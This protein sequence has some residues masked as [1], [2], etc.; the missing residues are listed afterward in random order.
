M[1]LKK[2]LMILLSLVYFD[3]VFNLNAYDS[4]SFEIFINIFL[5]DC[6]NSFLVYFLTSL[7][8]KKINKLVSYLIYAFL[9]FWYSLYYVFYRVFITPFS[10]ALFRQSD[11]LLKFGKNIVISVL[12]N[13]HVLILFMLPLIFLIVFRKRFKFDK[14]KFKGYVWGFSLLLCVVSLYVLNIFVQERGFGST[15]NLYFETNNVSL[16]IEKLGVPAA[17]FL[18]FYRFIFGVEEKIRVVETFYEGEDVSEEYDYNMLDLDLSG[19]TGDIEIINNY[20]NQETA[21]RKNKYTGMFE[22]M[23]LIY[24]VAES[25]SEIAV[26]PELTPTL[27]KLVHEGFDFENFYTSNN[28]STIGGEFQALTGLYAD[29]VMFSSWRGARHIIR[30]VWE[31]FLRIWAI[32]HMLIII[33]VLF[34]R[35]GMFILH[36]KG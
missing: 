21:T 22:G 17:S 30:M 13:F 32:I 9:W 4:Y 29:N 10:V 2:Y 35:I 14:L 27:Y 7:G 33:I 1:K 19:G 12:Q 25:F 18:D 34:F 3:L 31:L 28:L 15:Y 26:S 8:N 6:I 11:Q 36:L 20:M 23:N 24:I 16:N 5:F